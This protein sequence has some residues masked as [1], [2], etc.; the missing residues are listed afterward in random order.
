MSRRSR[1]KTEQFLVGEEREGGQGY[2]RGFGENEPLQDSTSAVDAVV[3]G[4]RQE[5]DGQ[6]CDQIDQDQRGITPT[7]RW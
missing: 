7:E 1:A 5:H 4:R 6:E 2:S 3:R